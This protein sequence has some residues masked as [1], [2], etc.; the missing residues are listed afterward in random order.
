MTTLEY[1]ERQVENH[2]RNLERET[3]RHVPE[4]MLRNIQTKINHYQVAVEALKKV[5]A[6]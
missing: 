4:E 6:V 3:A 2:K 1:M 5:G